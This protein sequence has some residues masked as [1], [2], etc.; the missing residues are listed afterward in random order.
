MG[1]EQSIND[2]F[3]NCSIIQD[4]NQRNDPIDLLIIRQ[5]NVINQPEESLSKMCNFLGL[6][7]LPDYLKDCASILYKSP[8][9]S[10]H[11]IE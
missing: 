9:H 3:R 8:A 2:Y 4:L 10:R 7:P 6:E 11:K 1:F 5:E